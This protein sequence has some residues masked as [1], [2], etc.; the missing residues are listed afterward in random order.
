MVVLD[1]WH[2]CLGSVNG[3]GSHSSGSQFIP[4]LKSFRGEG[5]ESVLILNCIW[6][7]CCVFLVFVWSELEGAWSD[8]LFLG[9]WSYYACLA[10]LI[11]RCF[12]EGQWSRIVIIAVT[13]D[14]FWY[15]LVTN[16]A[17]LL[18]TTLIL[19]MLRWMYGFHKNPTVQAYSIIGTD[20]G[21]IS[22]QLQLGGADLDVV[23][24]ASLRSLGSCW[25]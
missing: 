8:R 2:S 14:V 11:L 10:L 19:A 13:L 20:E 18:W 9:V 5:M 22:S 15:W 6:Q 23:T 7:S 25:F 12:R 3:S 17:D 16:R 4:I 1:L 21:L 24:Q